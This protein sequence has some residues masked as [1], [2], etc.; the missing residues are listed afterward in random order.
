MARSLKAALVALYGLL[1]VSC[2]SQAKRPLV[3]PFPLRFPLT[4]VGR[5]EIEG[6]ILGQPR[7]RDAIIRFVDQEGF[8]T[9]IVVSSRSVLRRYKFI[10]IGPGSLPSDNQVTAGPVLMRDGAGRLIRT[11]S[12]DAS[13]LLEAGDG[14]GDPIW[15]FKAGGAILADP[16]VAGGRVYFGDAGQHFY[17]LDAETGKLRWKRTL[18]GAPLHPAVVAG[19][20]VAVAASNS[21][22]YRLSAKGGS[23]LSW[24]AV[25]SRIL[26]EPAAAG[27]LVLISSASPIVTAIDLR[28]GRR[29]G[30][31]EAPGILV[32]GAVWSSPYVVLFVE[33]PDTGRQRIVFLR[34]R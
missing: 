20:A 10:D 12:G 9:E 26:H 21:V 13:G 32:A 19:G 15:A 24:E 29:A 6:R 5:L 25:P 7:S 16:A 8:L 23:I 28:T 34:S 31:Y 3:D 27:P 33:D 11:L 30:Q 18:Q 17:C 4:E 2:V 22:V 14:K 1:A